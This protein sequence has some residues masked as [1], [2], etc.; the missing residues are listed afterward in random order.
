MSAS[1]LYK[2]PAKLEALRGCYSLCR[3]RRIAAFRFFFASFCLRFFLTDGF[4]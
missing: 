3:K 1:G 2:M 4:S